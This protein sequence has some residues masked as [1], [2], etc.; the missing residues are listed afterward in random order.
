VCVPCS[1]LFR[2]APSAMKEEGLGSQVLAGLPVR[3]RLSI[4]RSIG[5]TRLPPRWEVGPGLHCTQARE[6]PSISSLSMGFYFL[7]GE[8]ETYP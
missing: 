4:D 7:F 2:S 8:C 1:L 5:V 6:T 3:R